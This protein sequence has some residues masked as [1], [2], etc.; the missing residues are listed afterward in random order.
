MSDS[1]EHE[2]PSGGFFGSPNPKQA[3]QDKQ[4]KEEEREDALDAQEAKDREAE[5]RAE[6]DFAEWQR[7]NPDNNITNDPMDADNRKQERDRWEARKAEEE[8]ERAAKEK[9]DKER[10]E[11]EKDK[12][13][14]SATIAGSLASLAQGITGTE[15]ITGS[16][17]VASGLAKLI[18]KGQAK[19]QEQLAK[20]RED[21][22]RGGNE[23]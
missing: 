5:K 1:R 8:K 3:E 16:N 4:R 22:E 20:E 19:A 2:Q 11:K 13:R 12:E 17:S 23:R 18:E 9:A 15:R 10:A 21:R 7:N 14:N 6:K